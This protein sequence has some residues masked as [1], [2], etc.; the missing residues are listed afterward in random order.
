MSK[1][2]NKVKKKLMETTN[3]KKNDNAKKQT[4]EEG[5]TIKHGQKKWIKSDSAKKVER[6]ATGIWK[7]AKT[8]I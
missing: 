1:I 3:L 6:S 4:E 7:N 8:E 2:E 5:E